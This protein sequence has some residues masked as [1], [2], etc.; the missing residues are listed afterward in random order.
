M[1]GRDRAVSVVVYWVDFQKGGA[2]VWW[3][4][5]MSFGIGYTLA[6]LRACRG[7]EEPLAKEPTGVYKRD[8]GQPLLGRKIA[9]KSQRELRDL[10]LL[11]EEAI[12]KDRSR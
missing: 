12:G 5:L 3:P 1:R 11:V 10:G 7:W 2:S 8:D 4:S 6:A 9:G